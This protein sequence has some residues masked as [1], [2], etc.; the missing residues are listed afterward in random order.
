MDTSRRDTEFTAFVVAHRTDLVRMATLLTTGDPA[1]A[2]DLV[3]GTLTRLY[4]AW[5]KVRR[6]DNPVGYARRSL[7]NLFVDE[8]RRAHRRREATTADPALAGPEPRSSAPDPDLRAA[9]LAALRD[10]APRQRAVVVLRHW[11]DLDVAETARVLDRHREV[12][13][14]QGPRPPA[15][16]PRA[17]AATPHPGD[18]M[19]DL[20]RTLDLAAGTGGDAPAADADLARARQALVHRRRRRYTGGLAALALVAVGSVGVTV[21]VSNDDPAGPAATPPT[22]PPAADPGVRLVAESFDAAPYTFGL[23]PEGWSVQA[24]NDFGVVIAPDDGSVDDNPDSF[25]GKLVVMF[26]ANPLGDGRVEH[27]GR[28]FSIRGDSDH[29]TISTRTLPGEPEGVVRIQ[30][31]DS[32][33]WSEESMLDFLGSVHVGEG[34]RQSVG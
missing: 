23:T 29:T 18:A 7:T 17:S 31:P 26:D 15:A 22:T 9:V 8:S 28:T 14:R 12:P 24:S 3:Q 21:A 27:D 34:A 11:V 4:L 16:H 6:A 10:L 2:E 5:P 25:L 19:T 13:E 20:H 32:A 33:G 1:W 30:Y